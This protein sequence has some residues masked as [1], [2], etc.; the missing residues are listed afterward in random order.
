MGCFQTDDA[1]AA[2]MSSMTAEG[3]IPQHPIAE[4]LLG[5]ELFRFDCV[6]DKPGRKNGFAV[7]RVGK[8]PYGLF[9]N[10]RTGV[11]V[12]WYAAKHRELSTQRTSKFIHPLAAEKTVAHGKAAQK[13]AYLWN[14]CRA[15]DPTHPYLA[16]KA[17]N[18]ECIGQLGNKLVVPLIDINGH[19][20]NLQFIQPDGQKRF[21]KGGRI[22]GLFWLRPGPSEQGICIGEGV[23]TMA[24]VADATC[25]TVVAAFSASNLVPVATVIAERYPDTDITICADNDQHLV[26]NVGFEAAKKAAE[27]VGAWLA[28]A[29]RMPRDAE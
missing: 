8:N 5:G 3:V 18:P 6:G 1:I 25:R 19:I 4:E 28:V 15:A 2:F 13:A 29:D 14:K 17:I 9:G 22:V 23:A 21:L 24:A 11:R 26:R 7:L 27:A 16:R 12:Q 10:W 20:W